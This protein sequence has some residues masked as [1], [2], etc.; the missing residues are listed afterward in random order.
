MSKT[1]LTA[2]VLMALAGVVLILS[3]PPLFDAHQPNQELLTVV[4]GT[5]F[6]ALTAIVVILRSPKLRTPNAADAK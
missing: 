5:A 2:F 6:V 4:S 3:L 1:L